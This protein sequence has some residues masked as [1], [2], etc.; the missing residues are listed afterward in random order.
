[1]Q[2]LYCRQKLLERLIHHLFFQSKDIDQPLIV[3]ANLL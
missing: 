3:K 1:M 2:E